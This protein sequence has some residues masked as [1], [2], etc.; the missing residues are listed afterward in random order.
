MEASKLA[1]K[2]VHD[3]RE[4]LDVECGHGLQFGVDATEGAQLAPG[5]LHRRAAHPVDG[6]LWKG[7]IQE[8]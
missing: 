1:T 8:L 7:Y 6:G 4:M 2:M 5:E 3:L